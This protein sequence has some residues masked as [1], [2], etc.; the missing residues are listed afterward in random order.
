MVKIWSVFVTIFNLVIEM[1]VTL[2]IY[3][4]YPGRIL[5]MRVKV[6]GGEA[7]SGTKHVTANPFFYY[8]LN[9]G[10]LLLQSRLYFIIL[11][12]L[13]FTISFLKNLF[14]FC[15]LTRISLS[16][17]F[18]LFLFQI[19]FYSGFLSLSLSRYSIQ[20]KSFKC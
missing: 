11:P 2:M 19:H 18:F 14:R 17:P 3:F 10:S 4:Q 5:Q 6:G 9:V 8:Y 12:F 16:F 13:A 1:V 15:F 7:D 20:K